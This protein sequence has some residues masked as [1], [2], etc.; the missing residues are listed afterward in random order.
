VKVTFDGRDP[1]LV[2]RALDACLA[3]LPKDSV[4]RVER[5]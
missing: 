5:G 1:A 2:D 4:V 3:E